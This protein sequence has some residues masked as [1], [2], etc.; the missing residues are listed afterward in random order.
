MRERTV[1][2]SNYTECLTDCPIGE[3]AVPFQSDARFVSSA[4]HHD[5]L[6]N[7][8]TLLFHSFTFLLSPYSKPLPTKLHKDHQ[9]IHLT[10]E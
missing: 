10:T 5:W 1:T 9:I 2:N 4:L 6:R 7:P 3:S 8:A